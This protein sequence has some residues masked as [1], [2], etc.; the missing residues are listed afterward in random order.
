MSVVICMILNKTYHP[1]W[2]TQYL[3]SFN[4]C[5]PPISARQPLISQKKQVFRQDTETEEYVPYSTI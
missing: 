2:L 4:N 3:Y 1:F 5:V